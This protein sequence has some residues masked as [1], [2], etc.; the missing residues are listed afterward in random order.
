MVAGGLRL[1]GSW[2]S[3]GG[4]T[5]KSATDMAAIGRRWEEEGFDYVPYGDTTFRD[6][7]VCLG[8]IAASTTRVALGTYVTNP[9]TRSPLVTAQAIASVDEIS[10]GRAFLGIG[11]GN[12]ANAINGMPR[13]TPETLRGALR[14]INSAFRKAR[15][16]EPWPDG[17][18]IDERVNAFEW[19]KRRVPILV[20]ARAAKGQRI[21]AEMADGL[22]LRAGDV[23]HERLATVIR[24]VL[25]WRAE[26]P[27]AGD[28]F[29]IQI[30]DSAFI[31]DPD[32]GRRYLGSPT[33]T[34]ARAM[35]PDES[36]LDPALREQIL[37][38]QRRY[39]FGLH[40][41]S[42]TKSNIELL[43]ELE[44][45]D[46]MFDRFAFIGDE[47]AMVARFEELEVM[48]VTATHAPEPW[49]E[50]AGAVARYRTRHPLDPAAEPTPLR[51]KPH[52][53]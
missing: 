6:C 5:D 15:E 13:A 7:Y 49:R 47:K 4:Q 27:R 38:Y 21:A 25:N 42:L 17:I 41:S 29:E 18:E 37:E 26:G 35:N 52:L 36:G 1:H 33:A 16:H 2:S 32:K 22:M 40:G 11:M 10:G 44:I 39:E 43:Y 9:A 19:I 24:R 46:Y 23:P 48:G 51:P 50:G 3:T 12:S 45:A 28:P 53:R 20:A 34:R 8:A 31:G 14:T 30:L